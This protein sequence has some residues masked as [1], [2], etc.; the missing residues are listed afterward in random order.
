MNIDI[1][2]KFF[3]SFNNV[4]FHDEPHK[5]YVDGKELISVTTIIHRY[6][7]EFQE[8]YWSK[9]KADKYV[10]TQREVLRAWKFINKKGIIKGSAIHDYAENLFQNKIFPYPKQLILDEFGFDPVLDEYNITKKH[11]D[12]FYNDVKGKLIPIRTE[13]IIYD[14]ESLIGGMLDILFYNVKKKV[15]QI[16]DWKTNKKFDKVVK[17]RHFH[18][19]LMV[20]EDSDLE[21]YSLQL[22]MYKFI[23]EKITGIQLGESYVVWF[24]HNNDSYEIIKT[25]DREYYVK[26]IMADRLAEL[27]A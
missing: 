20:L 27:A 7:E 4:T 19:K 10:L 3:T 2:N 23:I 21:I 18:D 5:Y 22:A 1:P 26:M 9:Y 25:K 11:V 16:W 8:D 12:K 24:S 6:Q 15:F 13:M 14:N 17:S